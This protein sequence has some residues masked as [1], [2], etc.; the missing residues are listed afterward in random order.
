MTWVGIVILLFAVLG[1]F[2]GWRSGALRALINLIGLLA[3]IILSFE[4]KNF[5]GSIIISKMPFFNF[6]G[7]FT[8]IYSVN[9]LFYQSLAFI[10]VFLLLYCILNILINLSGMV[11]VIDRF[12]KMYK[13]PSKIGGAVIGVVESFVY[14]FIVVFVLLA[15]P[16]T[17]KF[18]MEDKVAMKVATNT[19]VLSRVFGLSLRVEQYQ[20]LR[21]KEITERTPENIEKAEQDILYELV[22][23]RVVEA[24]LVKEAQDLDKL[25]MENTFMLITPNM[26][27]K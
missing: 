18:M 23:K 14:V 22:D 15:I 25:H 8:D 6:G 24:D 4:F 9:F 5:L 16:G 2:L 12:T 20:Y 27:K 17:T 13:L 19:P 11:E 10:V 26:T 21:A 7:I 1:G 3:I